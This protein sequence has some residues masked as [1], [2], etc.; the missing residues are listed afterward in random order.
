[1]NINN[2]GPVHV[3]NENNLLHYIFYNTTIKTY[4]NGEQK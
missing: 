2:F 1:M 4:A 3:Q